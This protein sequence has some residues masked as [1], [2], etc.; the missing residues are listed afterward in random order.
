VCAAAPLREAHPPQTNS[1]PWAFQQARPARFRATGNPPRRARQLAPP[2]WLLRQVRGFLRGCAARVSE[3]LRRRLPRE[4]DL[5]R[6]RQ[7]VQPPPARDTPA[8]GCAR[9]PPFRRQRRELFSYLVP[10]PDAS[11]RTFS[12]ISPPAAHSLFIPPVALFGSAA[13]AGANA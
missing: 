5:D 12:P 13:A 7:L 3:I 4:L 8:R 9:I 6:K 10:R 11:G 2:R 1:G